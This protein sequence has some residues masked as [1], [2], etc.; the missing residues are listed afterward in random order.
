MLSWRYDLWNGSCL[1]FSDT[2]R[3]RTFLLSHSELKRLWILLYFYAYKNFYICILCCNWDVSMNSHHDIVFK[4][5][6]YHLGGLLSN[7]SMVLFVI[8]IFILQ[9][10]NCAS[11]FL[12]L[13]LLLLKLLYWVILLCHS[14]STSLSFCTNY[15]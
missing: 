10:F 6:T 13:F 12:H 9:I 3:I 8:S 15:H 5:W 7:F 1:R 4:P 14:F 2:L 11:L